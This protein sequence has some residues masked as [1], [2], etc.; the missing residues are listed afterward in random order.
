MK[1]EKDIKP[2]NYKSQSHGFWE[3][4]YHINNK[5]MFKAY[6]VNGDE[7]GYVEQYYDDGNLD[8]KEFTLI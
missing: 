4:Y 1:S 7:V 8:V 2:T 6:Y 3:I 5:L